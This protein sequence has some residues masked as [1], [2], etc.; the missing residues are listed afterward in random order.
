MSEFSRNLA[1]IIG[2]NEYKNGI[3]PLATAVNDAKKL[4]EILRLE[5]GYQVWIFLD[6]VATLENI[7]RLLKETLPQQVTVDDRLLFYFAGHGIALNGEE[8]PEGYLIPQNAKLGDTNSYLPMTQLQAALSDLPCRHF[9][10][11]LDCC[12]AGAF[13]YPMIIGLTK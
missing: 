8:G 11:I 4:N 9:L 6:Q 12:F 13:R 3:S 7:D 5:H 1:V 2:I 10:G